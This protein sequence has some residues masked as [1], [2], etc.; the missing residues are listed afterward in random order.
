MLTLGISTSFSNYAIIIA[1][2]GKVLFNSN[3]IHF[4]ERK[5]IT[6]WFDVALEKSK[7]SVKDISKIIVDIGPG[8]T[9][10]VRTGVAFANSLAF[11]LGIPVCPVTSIEL[12]TM[13][14]WNQ[15]ELPVVSLIKFMKNNYFVGFYDGKNDYQILYG[16]L[17]DILPDLLKNIH[18]FVVTGKFISKVEELFPEKEIVDL[19]ILKGD[20]KLLIEQET[21]FSVRALKFPQIAFPIS[22]QN[23]SN[24][25]AYFQNQ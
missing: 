1:K 7:I 10:S 5:N 4:E 14:S 18:E 19:S 22:E 24:N 8:G 12:L 16:E 3:D 23:Y 21:K 9:T 17:P 25:Q 6:E 20:V 15:K 2:E 11:S 13:T